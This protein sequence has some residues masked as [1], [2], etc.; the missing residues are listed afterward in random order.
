MKHSTRIFLFLSVAFLG[1]FLFYPMADVFGRTFFY[2]GRFSPGLFV[3][4]LSSPVIRTA[5]SNSFLMALASVLFSSLIALPLAVIFSNYDFPLKR[6]LSG[7]TL[8]PLILPPFVGALGIQRLFGRYGLVNLFLGTAPFDWLSQTGLLSV[9]FLQSLHLFPIMYLNLTAALSNINPEH[10]EAARLCGAGPSRVFRDITL[11]LAL[12]GFYA[13]AVIVFLWSFT[14]IGTPLILGFRR[15]LAVEI[16]DRT[17]AVNSD[18]TGPAM[19]VFVALITFFFIFLFKRFLS[20]DASGPGGKGVRAAEIA[21]P[22]VKGL[23]FIYPFLFVVLFIALLPHMGIVLMSI[24]EKWFMTAL[25]EKIG[26]GF[27]RDALSGS[28]VMLSAGNSLLYSAV[29]TLAD[30][31][32]GFWF[33]YLIVRRKIRAGWVMDAVVML[34]L[35]LPG[36]VLAFGYLAA[37]SG[38]FLDPLVNP[39]PLLIIGYAV[40]RL[41]YTFRAAY[42]GLQQVGPEY[43]E[44][45][46][47]CGAGPLRSVLTIALPLSAAGLIAG[48]ILAFMY[49]MLEVS[50]SMILAV[51]E[52][53]F[54]ITRELYLLRG[55]LP[56]GDFV[57]SALGVLCMFFLAVGLTAAAT[58]LGKHLGKMFRM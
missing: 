10:K 55:K 8:V 5:L 53:F 22:S 58:L 23:F 46:R 24:A 27:Y 37:F 52:Q 44:A 13:G 29:S 56:D 7:I 6:L 15:A 40:R 16:F 48:A 57:A 11:P 50:E 1:A 34:P 30:V 12:P 9:A 4:T 45:A 41:P 26:L 35:A 54:P 28:G 36:L 2:Q 49:A 42:A 18:P 38:T 21:R 47:V 25:P 3:L 51:K 19:V 20:T 39:V 32:L 43:E 14:D 17:S 33:A 31:V